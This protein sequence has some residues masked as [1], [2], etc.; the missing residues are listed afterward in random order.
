MTNSGEDPTLEM[1]NT[2]FWVVTVYFGGTPSES[3][4]DSNKK[5]TEAEGKLSLLISSLVIFRS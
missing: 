1:K 4:S 2:I 5:P 3:K